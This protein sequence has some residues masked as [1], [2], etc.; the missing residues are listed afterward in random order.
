MKANKSK[1]NFKKGSKQLLVISILTGIVFLVGVLLFLNLRGSSDNKE[2]KEVEEVDSNTVKNGIH[3]A[4]GFI[5]EEGYQ[6]VI[7]NCTICHSSQLVIQ[8]RMTKEAWNSTIKWMQETQNLW[9]LGANQEVIVNYL[10][11]NYPPI[12]KGRRS[13][14]IVENW[15]ELQ[16]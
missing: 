14:L 11:A 6:T 7:Q 2:F 13:N 12:E 10:V 9:E 16:E 5:A 3:L 1:E 4:T 15:Y 8:N